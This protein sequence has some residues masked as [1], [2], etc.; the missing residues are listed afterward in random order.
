V[1]ARYALADTGKAL[2]DM[3]ARKVTGKVVI[4]P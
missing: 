3:A 1:S 4:A 2:D